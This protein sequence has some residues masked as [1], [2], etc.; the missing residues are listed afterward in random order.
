MSYLFFMLFD[1]IPDYESVPIYFVYIILIII[2]S[3]E[4][5]SDGNRKSNHIY[6]ILY[7]Y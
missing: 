1:L 3:L 4:S 5:L 7:R 2:F 6:T